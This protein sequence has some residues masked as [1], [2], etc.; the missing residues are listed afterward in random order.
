MTGNKTEA[1]IIRVQPD[2]KNKLQQLADADRRKLSDFVRLQLEKI[3][4]PKTTK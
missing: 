3:A 4:A 2:L 1:I